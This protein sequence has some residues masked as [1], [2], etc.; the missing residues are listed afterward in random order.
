MAELA[1]CISCNKVF[2]KSSR[3]ICRECYQVEEE[4]F[5][6]V[7]RYLMKKKNREATL[8]EIAEATGVDKDLIIKFLKENRLRATQFSNLSYPCEIC[9]KDISTGR[10]CMKCSEEIINEFK[11]EEKQH[12]QNEK[13]EKKPS[14]NVYYTF[15]TDEKD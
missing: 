2:V 8:L 12:K 9:G 13:L 15:T 10:F 14:Q 4:A 3:P 5:E 1:N 11:S 7:Y 6:K